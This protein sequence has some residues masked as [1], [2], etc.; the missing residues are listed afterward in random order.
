LHLR[1]PRLDLAERFGRVRAAFLDEREPR[2]EHRLVEPARAPRLA[3]RAEA[4][5]R[6]LRFLARILELA[7]LEAD[8]ELLPAELEPRDARRAGH[9]FLLLSPQRPLERAE[10]RDRVVRRELA[11]PLDPRECRPGVA[12]EHRDPRE[13]DGGR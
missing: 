8:G 13:R 2:P 1:R 12:L 11:R 5:P 10:R 6:L 3:D 4:V 9:V 7:P